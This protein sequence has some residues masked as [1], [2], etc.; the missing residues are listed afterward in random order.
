[1]SY[2]K[3]NIKNIIVKEIGVQLDLSKLNFSET[4]MSFEESL[5]E[6]YPIDWECVDE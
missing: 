3:V 4:P 2:K 5:H 1:M 6:V